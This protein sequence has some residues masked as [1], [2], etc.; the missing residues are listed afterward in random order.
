MIRREGWKELGLGHTRHKNE[1]N[2]RKVQFPSISSHSAGVAFRQ[3]IYRSYHAF[4]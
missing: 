4:S 3:P 2:N 1:D